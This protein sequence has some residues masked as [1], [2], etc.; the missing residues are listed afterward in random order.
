MPEVVLQDNFTPA[1][2][3]DPKLA[4]RTLPVAEMVAVRAPR[5]TTAVW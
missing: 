5:L 2:Y 3:N 1:L 4:A